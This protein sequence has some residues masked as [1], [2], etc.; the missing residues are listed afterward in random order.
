MTILQRRDKG[1]G[2]PRIG[3]CVCGFALELERFTNTCRCGRDYNSSG[4]ELA[5]RSQWGEDTSETV[6]DILSIGHNDQSENGG[7]Q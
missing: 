5:P 4:Q 3:R 1:R 2:L 6:A 7:D